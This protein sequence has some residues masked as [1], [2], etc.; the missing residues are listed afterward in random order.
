MKVTSGL[1][2]TGPL[3]GN[4]TYARGSRSSHTVGGPVESGAAQRGPVVAIAPV[5]GV[6]T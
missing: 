5:G 4:G 1:G 6:R 2:R 3:P